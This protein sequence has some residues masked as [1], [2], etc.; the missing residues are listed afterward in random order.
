MKRIDMEQLRN[1]QLQVLKEV[2]AYC[3]S[4][5]IMYFLTGGT[6]IG[7]VR[8]GGY[9]PWDDDID[10]SMHRADY[11]KFLEEF[12]SHNSDYKV[13]SLK[14]DPQFSYPFAKIAYEK[15]LLIEGIEGHDKHIGINIDLFPLDTIPEDKAKQEQ[16]LSLVKKQRNILTLRTIKVRK[17]RAFHKNAIVFVGKILLRMKK[18]RKLAENISSIPALFASADNKCAGIVVWGYGNREIVDKSVFDATVELN[19]EGL[20]FSAPAKYDEWL[21]TVYGDYMKLPPLEKQISTH[22]N[23]AYLLD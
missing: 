6:L 22:A 2:D 10:I 19:F 23:E 18:P 9:I 17:G 21:K 7:A 15:S 8:H 11:E 5:G 16:L 3:K 4:K 13:Y 12:N 1:I 14:T 20:S